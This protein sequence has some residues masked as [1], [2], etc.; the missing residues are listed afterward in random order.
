VLR[1]LNFSGLIP[2]V[3]QYWRSFEKLFASARDAAGKHFPAW[4]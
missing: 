2:M 3:Q 1:R 4:R